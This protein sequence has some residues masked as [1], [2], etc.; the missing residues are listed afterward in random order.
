MENLSLKFNYFKKTMK[1]TNE[2]IAAMSGVPVA[3]IERISSGRTKNPN[4]K[5]MKALAKVFECSLNDL[6]NLT[7]TTKPYYLDDVTGQIAQ[8]IQNDETLKTLFDTMSAL[9]EQNKQ[10]VTGFAERLK[11]MQLQDFANPKE[12]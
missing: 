10:V 8:T 12:G 1:L 3:T 2:K 7:T 6:I 9:N 11:N 4:L 5:T